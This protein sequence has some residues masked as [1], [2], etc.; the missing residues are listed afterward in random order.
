MAHFER[1]VAFSLLHEEIGKSILRIKTEYMQRFGLRSTDALFLA[2]LD[3]HPEGMTAAALARECGVDKAVVSRALPTLLSSGAVV[4]ADGA[5]NRHGY[6]ARL[7]LS[8]R[9][10]EIV[11]EMQAFSVSAVKAA[12]KGI[13]GEEIA[14]FY[15]VLRAINQNLKEHTVPEDEEGENP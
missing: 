6:R 14:V 5:E 8:A 1:F 13:A 9:G 3:R 15:R 2:M 10:E 4:Y 11:R 7:C 12:S